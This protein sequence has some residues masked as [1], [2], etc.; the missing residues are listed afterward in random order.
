M[1][2]RGLGKGAKSSLDRRSVMIGAALASM[3]GVSIIRTPEPS[4]RIVPDSRFRDA[5]PSRVGGWTSR[6]SAEL[7]LPELD[8]GE[9]LYENLETRIYE[10]RDLPTIMFLVAYSSRQINDIQVH[11]PEVCY[12]VAG[13]PIKTSEPLT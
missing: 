3:A 10:G 12:P 6:R 13:F 4:G 1:Q 9:R 7:V 5:I 2:T 11:R 8:G